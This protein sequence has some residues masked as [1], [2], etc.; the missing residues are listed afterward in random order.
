MQTI[1]TPFCQPTLD[2]GRFMGPIIVKN[3]MDVRVCRNSMINRI[4]EFAKFNR[5][6]ICRGAPGRG[7]SSRPSKWCAINLARHFPTVGPVTR[8]AAATS[9]FFLPS[10]QAKISR[11]RKANAWAV[12]LLRDHRSKV[13]RSSSLRWRGGIGRPIVMVVLLSPPT[14]EEERYFVNEFITQHTRSREDITQSIQPRL[15]GANR[16][17]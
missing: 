14:I 5:S 15:D 12:F 4:K 11:A 10:A 1:A 7:S 8:N 17:R 16:G 13:S 6:V 3:Q 2:H 9:P